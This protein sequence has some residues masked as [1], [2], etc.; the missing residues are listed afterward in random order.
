MA[1]PLQSIFLAVHL[2]A[3]VLDYIAGFYPTPIQLASDFFFTALVDEMMYQ[4]PSMPCSFVNCYACLNGDHT[5]VTLIYLLSCV[6]E[7][8]A[9]L[10]HLF[11]EILTCWM[12]HVA[13]LRTATIGPTPEPVNYPLLESTTLWITPAVRLH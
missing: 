10:C 5:G 9:E 1:S 11:P 6:N 13:L 7:D 4:W 2:P 8:P 12:A 3:P